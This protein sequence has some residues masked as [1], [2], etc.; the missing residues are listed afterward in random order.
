M[1]AAWALRRH[2][3]KAPPMS[4]AATTQTVATMLLCAVDVM[5]PEPP[6]PLDEAAA[7]VSAAARATLGRGVG[8]ATGAIVGAAIGAAVGAGAGLAVGLPG[9]GEGGGVGFGG[10]SAFDIPRGLSLSLAVRRNGLLHGPRG[11]GQR[12]ALQLQRPLRPQV[13]YFLLSYLPTFLPPTSY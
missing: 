2:A 9:L 12:G 7:T 4:T 11:A 5:V 1:A 13:T 10:Q 3:T 6:E 8:A